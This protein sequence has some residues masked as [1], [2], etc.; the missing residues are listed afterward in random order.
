[1]L[2]ERTV[3]CS[4]ESGGATQARVPGRRRAHRERKRREEDGRGQ[5]RAPARFGGRRTPEHLEDAALAISLAARMLQLRLEREKAAEQLREPPESNP[6]PGGGGERMVW[7]ASVAPRR[8]ESCDP[9]G[10]GHS[11]SWAP[12]SGVKGRGKAQHTQGL[13]SPFSP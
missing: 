11:W 1:M 2:S 7:V 3:F 13:R 5:Q 4:A 8:Q 9:R 12:G 10:L 6:A